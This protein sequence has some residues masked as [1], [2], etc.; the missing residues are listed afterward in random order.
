MAIFRDIKELTRAL[1]QSS[2]LLYDMFQKRKSVSIRY[3]DA[4]DTLGGDESRLKRLI[5]FGVI[6]QV[7]ENLEL[8]DAYQQFFENVLAVNE[9]INIASIASYIDSLKLNI[10]SYLEAES[11][12][13]PKFLREIRHIFRS[14]NASTRRNVV[15]LKRNVEYTYK[16]EP[17]FKIKELRL[18]AFDEKCEIITQMIQETRK[19]IET[20]HVFFKSGLDNGLR[21]TLDEV[22]NGLYESSHGLIS[23]KAQIIDYLNR[24]EQQNR[25]VKKVRQLKYLRDQFMIEDPANTDIKAV[26]SGRN[27]LWMES[28]PRYITKVSVDFL[29]ND[30]AALDILDNIRRRIEKKHTFANRLADKIDSHYL[31]QQEEKTFCFNHQDIIDSFMAQSDHLFSFVKNYPFPI[32]VDEEQRLVLFL[33]LASQYHDKIVFSHE[34]ATI[35]DI[36]YPIIYSR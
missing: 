31:E 23:V 14:I 2:D 12:R 4:L 21:Q 24:I 27:D 33:Q 10:N 3:Y 18:K 1:S 19:L 26:A 36:E 20:E 7:G 8:E 32:A 9:E 5:E 34:T 30:D 11:N 28:K 17:N 13:Q 15:D 35:G 16:Q 22:R 29:R 25:I 6:E